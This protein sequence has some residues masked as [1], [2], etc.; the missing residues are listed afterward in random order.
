MT[1]FAKAMP[2]RFFCGKFY[3]FIKPRNAGLDKTVK[4]GKTCFFALYTSEGGIPYMVVRG[5]RHMNKL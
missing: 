3:I 5:E 4:N 1:F 2:R